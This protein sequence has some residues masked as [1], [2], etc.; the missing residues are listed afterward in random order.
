M[1]RHQA[2]ASGSSRPRL[3]EVKVSAVGSRAL[4]AGSSC[5][6]FC[7]KWLDEISRGG[8]AVLFRR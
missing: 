4:P 7:C 1:G 5:P 3:A 6:T 8:N 2:V